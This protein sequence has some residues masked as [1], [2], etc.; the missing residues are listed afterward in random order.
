MFDN[1]KTTY[2]YVITYE[3]YRGEIFEDDFETEV[4][5]IEEAKELYLDEDRDICILDIKK[6]D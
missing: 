4:D 2:T 5:T 1:K 3:D 6:I